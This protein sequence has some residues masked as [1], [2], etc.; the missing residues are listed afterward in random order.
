MAQLH[1]VISTTLSGSKNFYK[2]LKLS[3]GCQLKRLVKVYSSSYK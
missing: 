1:A 3:L 2:I